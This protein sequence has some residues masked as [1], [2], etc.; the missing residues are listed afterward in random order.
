MLF[1]G[2]R[3][4]NFDLLKE[5]SKYSKSHCKQHPVNLELQKTFCCLFC[6]S[7]PLTVTTY[8]PSTGYVPGQN[9]PI[10]I[11][12]DNASNVEIQRVRISLRQICSFKANSPRHG[13]KKAMHSIS[14]TAV[15]RIAER[16][17][18]QQ[19]VIL[20]IP[21]IPPSYLTNCTLIDLDYVLT[22]RTK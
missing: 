18:S 2:R 22:V 9:V 14:E 8:V 10:P 5:L 4:S 19:T 21:S 16:S 17:S 7:G 12:I 11:D 15:G 3:A 6:K 1:F 20:T 13:L